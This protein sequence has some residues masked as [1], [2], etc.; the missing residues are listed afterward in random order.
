MKYD[1]EKATLY[2]ATGRGNYLS[3][4]LL[5][6]V[7][8]VIVVPIWLVYLVVLVIS[9]LFTKWFCS[10]K[11]V[12]YRWEPLEEVTPAQKE[13]REFE[14][15]ICGATGFT[16]KKGVR[17]VCEHYR[18]KIRWAIAGRSQ[19]KLN[20]VVELFKSE[21]P[22]VEIKT[23][24]CDSLK[25]EDVEALVQRTDSVASFVG[26]F[27]KYG[28]PLVR[29]CAKFGTQYSDSTGES[30]WVRQM[31]SLYHLKAEKSKARIVN[32]TGFDSIP[33]D[34]VGYLAWKKITAKGENLKHVRIADSMKGGLSGGTLATVFAALEAPKLEA[35]SV[36]FNPDLMISGGKKATS[37]AKGGRIVKSSMWDYHKEVD[38][39]SSFTVFA[40]GNMGSIQRSAAYHG[41]GNISFV[42]TQFINTKTW[43]KAFAVSA[44]TIIGASLF[45]F[46]PTRAILM[47]F[48]PKPGE[49]PDEETC[50]N[51]KYWMSAVGTGDKGS[52]A[53]ISLGSNRGDPGYRDTG[54]MVVETAICLGKIRDNDDFPYGI[55]SPGVIA[56]PLLEKLME[57][58]T[59]VEAAY[60]YQL[61]N[62]YGDNK[63]RA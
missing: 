58:G 48:L 27:I 6:L 2:H 19:R 9:T 16:G 62:F 44:F 32:K 35:P 20:A 33:A 63:K 39:Y 7:L 31:I 29:A 13:N 56:E 36:G 30:K 46:G 50:R 18:N 3:D 60:D 10:K 61:G 55:L 14:L 57:S 41:Y 28:A 26:P 15:I 40:G 34:L 5:F 42:E 17:F 59:V 45:A 43:F 37:K 25:T 38:A 23:I 53:Y 22:N 51:G 8:I 52:K 12:V 47:M 24:I 49:G 11:Q 21:F 4:V 1:V 54:R